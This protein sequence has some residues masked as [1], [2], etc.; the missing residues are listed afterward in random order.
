MYS[1]AWQHSGLNIVRTSKASEKTEKETCSL[2]HDP[3][4][5]LRLSG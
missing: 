1:H 2:F 3:F 5:T 4:Y